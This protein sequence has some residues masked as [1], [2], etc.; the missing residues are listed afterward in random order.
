MVAQEHVYY[1]YFRIFD[2]PEISPDLYVIST[3]DPRYGY[4]FLNTCISQNGWRYS[5]HQA[6]QR[7]PRIFKQIYLQEKNLK[8][9]W[10]IV[11]FTAPY[12]HPRRRVTTYIKDMPWHFPFNAVLQ[13]KSLITN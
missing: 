4:L 9:D 8:Y 7:I 5:I 12:F 3:I 6:K 13:L 11:C 10:A 1:L 2:Y